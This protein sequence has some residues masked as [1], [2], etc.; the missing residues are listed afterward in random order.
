ML[1]WLRAKHHF[2]CYMRLLVPAQMKRSTTLTSPTE[3]FF[4]FVCFSY[5]CN[6]MAKGKKKKN[7]LAGRKLSLDCGLANTVHLG[8]EAQW[9]S[10]GRGSCSV[11]L[12]LPTSKR[13]RELSS[14]Q[15]RAITA[16]D[17]PSVSCLPSKRFPNVSKHHTPFKCMT[18]WETFHT[19]TTALIN[20][21]HFDEVFFL[22]TQR[23]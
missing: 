20:I 12:W 6:Q 11:W 3:C 15:G 13:V 21:R 2:T 8:G 19:Q 18:L 14:K 1:H 23:L 10:S 22:I 16:G 17:P 5:P 7:W 9:R 4:L